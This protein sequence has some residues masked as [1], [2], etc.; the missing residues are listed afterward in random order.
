MEEALQ[1]LRVFQPEPI[2]QAFFD[3]VIFRRDFYRFEDFQY[4]SVP[5]C[6][7]SKRLTNHSLLKI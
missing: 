3:F 4:M 5:S 7:K 1:H 2:H 6:E